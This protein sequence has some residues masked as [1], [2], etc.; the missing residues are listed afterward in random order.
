MATA[1]ASI[2][3]ATQRAA[4]ANKAAEEER[5]ARVMLE[6]KLAPRRITGE[7]QAKFTESCNNINKSRITV[8]AMLGVADADDFADDLARVLAGCGYDVTLTKSVIVIS[9][10]RGLRM[11]VG[12]N[13]QMEGILISKA[14]HNTGIADEIEVSPAH[15]PNSLG[16]QVGPKPQ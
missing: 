12:S 4:E 11:Y 15:D 14:L 1:Q 10:P 6:A 3:T 2:A 16:L 9:T 7:Q 5:L 13:R 8:N